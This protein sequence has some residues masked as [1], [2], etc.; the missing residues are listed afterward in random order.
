MVK[1]GVVYRLE[2]I[3]NDPGFSLNTLRTLIIHKLLG[4]PVVDKIL[5]EELYSEPIKMFEEEKADEQE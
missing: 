2:I 1:A 5:L 3:L 4:I